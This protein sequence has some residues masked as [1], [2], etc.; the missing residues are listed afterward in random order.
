MNSVESVLRP[1]E[2]LRWEIFVKEIGCERGVKSEG[3]TDG[4]TGESAVVEDVVRPGEGKSGME[5][6]G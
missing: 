6:L 1:E 5:R 2:S 3:V 4:G